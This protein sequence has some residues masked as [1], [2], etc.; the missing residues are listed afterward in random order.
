MSACHKA[1]GEQWLS[2]LSCEEGDHSGPLLE[3]VQAP[4]LPN[5]AP[6]PSPKLV[7]IT[8]HAPLAAPLATPTGL[9][10]RC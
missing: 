8:S 1:I 5:R 6:H 2:Y 4:D 3:R 10:R 7:S 9:F